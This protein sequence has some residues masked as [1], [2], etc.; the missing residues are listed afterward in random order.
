MNKHDLLSKI[1]VFSIETS[2]VLDLDCEIEFYISSI[3]KIKGNFDLVT[4]NK[5]ISTYVL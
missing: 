3:G 5:V 2:V 4:F 1:Q